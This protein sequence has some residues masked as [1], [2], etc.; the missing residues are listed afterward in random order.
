MLTLLGTS[1]FQGDQPSQR[2]VLPDVPKLREEA[3]CWSHM[4]PTVGHFGA[5]ATYMRAAQR[6]YWPGMASYLKREIKKCDICLAK[7]TTVKTHEAIQ[8]LILQTLIIQDKNT[9]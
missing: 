6:F 1:K 5:T 8:Q 4:H 3:Y 9:F 2:I 7:Q